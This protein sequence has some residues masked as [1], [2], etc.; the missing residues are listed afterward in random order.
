MYAKT[1][2]SEFSSAT[3][4]H[5]LLQKCRAQLLQAFA[6]CKLLHQTII[7]AL[8]CDCCKRATRTAESLANVL[9][10]RGNTDL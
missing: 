1:S 10:G 5:R 2:V 9:G 3:I 8:H 4:C 6:A 7:R